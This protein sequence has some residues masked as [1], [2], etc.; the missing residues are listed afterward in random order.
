MTLFLCCLGKM[1]YYT[2]PINY[3]L[4]CPIREQ[5]LRQGLREGDL[6]KAVVDNTYLQTG[7]AVAFSDYG[8]KSSQKRQSRA[9]P[10]LSSDNS[11]GYS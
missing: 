7:I 5:K 10:A 11:I 4:K 6:G 2:D 9:D 8:Q 1:N 3:D